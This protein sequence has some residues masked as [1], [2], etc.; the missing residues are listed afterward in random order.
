MHKTLRRTASSSK[1][2]KKKGE[3]TMEFDAKHRAQ[4]MKTGTITVVMMIVTFILG[5]L[6]MHV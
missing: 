5:I 6:A 3:K 2:Y 1:K 4:M